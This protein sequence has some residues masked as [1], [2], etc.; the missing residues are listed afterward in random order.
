[1]VIITSHPAMSDPFMLSTRGYKT[2]KRIAVLYDTYETIA[3]LQNCYDVVFSL[4]S[5][6][7]K[8]RHD[9]HLTVINERQVN[10]YLVYSQLCVSRALTDQA[11]K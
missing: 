1:M 8:N 4:R 11:S 9:F 3:Q 5:T 10:S 2:L 6:S 7:K